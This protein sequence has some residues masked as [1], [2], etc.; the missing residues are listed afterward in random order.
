MRIAIANGGICMGR[1]GSEQAAIRLAEELRA[2]GYMSLLLTTKG[3]SGPLYPIPPDLPVHF[4]PAAFHAGQADS[5]ADGGALLRAHGI[6]A[7][8][9]FESDWK[10]A[11]WQRCA[12]DAGAAF[13]CS[14]RINPG[15]AEREF[16]NARERRAMLVACAGIHELL[17]CYL[18]YIP[19]ELRTK[20]FV[21]PNAA[22]QRPAHGPGTGAEPVLLY[23][24]RFFRHK[25]PEL[26]LR[27]FGL[28]AG[29]FPAWRL[30]LLGWGEEQPKLEK[31]ALELGLGHRVEIRQPASGDVSLEYAQAAIYC[32]PSFQEG[33]PNTVLEAMSHGLPVVGI[34]DCLAMTSIISPGVTGLLAPKATPRD[35]AATLRP[36]LASE[37]P[38]L[39][40]GRAA[41]GHCREHYA[42]ARVFDQWEMELTGITAR[43]QD[44]K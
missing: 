11:L 3:V 31:T 18:K 34:S 10:H 9:S 4:F 20:A 41:L 40:M 22:P 19:P 7:L 44:K 17:P 6:D 32:L 16:W 15:L 23:L 27:A 13:V 12:A 35:L 24:G 25:R 37:T 36:L 5:I 39:R 33:F 14:E 29:E 2:R 42:P 28:L 43:W 21:I 30:R 26:L 8:V 1:G 38:R